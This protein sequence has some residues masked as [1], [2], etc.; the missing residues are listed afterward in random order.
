MAYLKIGEFQLDVE[1]ARIINNGTQTALEPKVLE[2]LV[3][4]LEQPGRVVSKEELIENVWKSVVV[5]PNALH[6]CIGQLRKAFNDNVKEQSYIETHPKRGYC[7]VAPVSEGASFDTD[8]QLIENKNFHVSKM[9]S[10]NVIYLV[11]LLTILAFIFS[12]TLSKEDKHSYQFSKLTSITATDAVEANSVFSPSGKEL[13][14]LRENESRKDHIW[15]LN[16]ETNEETRLTS[17]AASYRNLA[18]SPNAE[19]LAFSRVVKNGELQC[20]QIESLLVTSAVKRSQ[21]SNVLISCGA[22]HYEAPQWLD[23]KRLF[24]IKHTGR[25]SEVILFD[26]ETGEVRDVFSDN[27]NKIHS[28]SLFQATNSLAITILAEQQKPKVLLYQIKNQS[29]SLLPIEVP[30]KFSHYTHW[31]PS[32]DHLGKGFVFSVGRYLLYMSLAGEFTEL[33]TSDAPD[34]RRAEVSPTGESIVMTMGKADRDIHLISLQ[35]HQD[36]VIGRSTVKEFDAK[37]NP[38]SE[39]IAF[40]SERNGAINVWTEQLG[41][42]KQVSNV[43]GGVEQFFWSPSGN[44]LLLFHTGQL[45]IVSVTDDELKSKRIKVG[46]EVTRVFQWFKPNQLLCSITIGGYHHLV[47]LNVVTGEFKKLRQGPVHWAQVEGDKLVV[48]DQT[49]KLIAVNHLT[50]KSIDIGQSGIG[51]RQFFLRSNKVYFVN[52]SNELL[53]YDLESEAIELL[54][55]LSSFD[56]WLTDIDKNGER[57]LTSEVQSRKTELVLFHD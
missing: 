35:S 18:W 11:A 13:V 46:G 29:L 5:E 54:V 17:E 49:N 3:I 34:L 14:F 22:E 33:H 30:E 39:Q 56:T 8:Q 43:A 27:K 53:Q 6:R 38:K 2:V 55:T 47:A 48:L 36:R 50:D 21:P 32:W 12:L 51:N 23:N 37:F 9:A 4:L 26:T 25:T 31:H 7:L 42:V 52:K 10:K 28:I 19:R 24:T 15:W 40:L 57:L 44:E 41:G 16:L 1:R 45:E 20:T